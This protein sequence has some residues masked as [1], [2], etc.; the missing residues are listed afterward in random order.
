MAGS[1]D[2]VI[3][4]RRRDGLLGRLSSG[5]AARLFRPRPGGRQGHDLRRAA[6][7][8][9][10]S[11]VR[12]QFSSPINIRVG[13]YGVAFVRRACETLAVDGEAPELP[14]TENGYLYLASQSGAA[15]LA[16]N[17]SNADAEGADVLLL[18]RGD[19]SGAFP[20]SIVEGVALAR[21][22]A[23]AAKAGSTAM[24]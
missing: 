10:L 9:S 11:S 16:Q 23:D 14:F 24:R 4:R 8:L 21:L 7:S 13:L 20:S 2:V 18:E 22:R 19:S 17:Q 3:A 1:Y 15:A 12:Q 6:S 5:R